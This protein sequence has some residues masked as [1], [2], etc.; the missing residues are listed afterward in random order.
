M[1]KKYRI[2]TIFSPNESDTDAL[3]R[4]EL[5]M[6]EMCQDLRL[7]INHVVRDTWDFNLESCTITEVGEETDWTDPKNRRDID[8]HPDFK[9]ETTEVEE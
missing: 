4:G 1:G 6:E 8:E 5:D 3:A 9:E 7:E 2:E